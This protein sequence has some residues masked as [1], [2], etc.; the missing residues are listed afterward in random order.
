MLCD[1]WI[2][3]A[4]SHRA[5]QRVFE[6]VCTAAVEQNFDVLPPLRITTPTTLYECMQND[7]FKYQGKG[8]QIL[9]CG[10]FKARTAEE[11]DLLRMGKLQS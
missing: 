9:I 2:S 5:W 4:V 1:I 11:P 3:H 6:H 8:A 7:V 10:D